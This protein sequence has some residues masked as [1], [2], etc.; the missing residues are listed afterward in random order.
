MAIGFI[1]FTSARS[2]VS[3]QKFARSHRRCPPRR[4]AHNRPPPPNQ[5][6][7]STPLG[8]LSPS[9]A[10]SVQAPGTRGSVLALSQ[11]APLKS[12]ISNLKSPP[13][14]A[15]SGLLGESQLSLRTECAYPPSEQ[16]TYQHAPFYYLLFTIYYFSPLPTRHSHFSLPPPLRPREVARDA[17]L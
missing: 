3:T 7:P 5:P 17:N 16:A 1:K 15:G 13:P 11:Q 8:A 10:F 6:S 14:A 4:P 2:V 9:S 12:Q